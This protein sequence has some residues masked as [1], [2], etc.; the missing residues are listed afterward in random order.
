MNK[1]TES[2]PKSILEGNII[3]QLLI[4]RRILLLTDGRDKLLKIAQYSSK[5]LLWKVLT[6]PKS[7]AQAKAK[8]LVSHLSLARKIIRLAHFLEPLKDGLD[9][10]NEKPDFSSLA[11]K[12]APLNVVIGILNDLSDDAICLGKMG[13]IDSWWIEKCTPVS[14]RLWYM[15]IFID[16]HSNVLDMKKLEVK[17]LKEEDQKAKE[18]LKQK[19]LMARVSFVKLMMDF[20]FCTV[21]VFQLK[22]SDG[23]QACAGFFAALLGTYKLYKKNI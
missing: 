22:V 6:V 21:D 17:Y 14:D 7:A 4:W 2:G 5:V 20:I 13:M 19:L 12:L 10:I 3:Y 16:L 11:A 15:S 18:A 9:L 1:K 8:L 23:V